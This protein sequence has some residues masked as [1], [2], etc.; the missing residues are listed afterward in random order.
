MQIKR[1][2][3]SIMTRLKRQ[4]PILALCV[5]SFASATLPA[6]DPMMHPTGSEESPFAHVAYD[7]LIGIKNRAVASGNV[8][9]AI[10]CLERLLKI[11]NDVEDIASFMV[12]IADLLFVDSR[13]EKAS[14]IYEKFTQLYPGS[15]QAE[16]AFY[17]AIL[18]RSYL[19]PSVDRDQ[20]KTEEVIE[21]A[22]KFLR[23]VT[24]TTH[25]AQVTDLRAKAYEQ[26]FKAESEI[27]LF[28]AKNKNF[29]ASQ[30]RI[31]Y[32]RTKLLTK[33]P[34]LEPRILAFEADI[35]QLF[36]NPTASEAKS[37]ELHEKFPIEQELILA[38]HV[39]KQSWSSW[40]KVWA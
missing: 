23:K 37:V 20:T 36:N 40:F 22:D 4:I 17:R 12:E 15:K 39:E 19:I 29:L 1:I 16:Y 5:W 8:S 14:L 32:M 10:S 11:S 38:E 24:F 31:D 35:A 25:K 28:Y 6:K 21:L 7:D 33:E 13:F 2:V 9:G 18:A 26:L 3:V 30:R 27:C 34:L